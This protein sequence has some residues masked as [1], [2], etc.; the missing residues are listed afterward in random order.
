MFILQLPFRIA[1]SWVWLYWMNLRNLSGVSALLFPWS[2]R[3]L[4]S[5]MTLMVSTS[6]STIGTQTVR[7]RWTL[8]GWRNRG[9]WFWSVWL[10][11][12]L[13][14]KSTSISVEI[15]ECGVFLEEVVRF[16]QHFNT[17]IRRLHISIKHISGLHSIIS[18]STFF[19]GKKESASRIIW[20]S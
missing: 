1:A 13:F 4:P 15:T 6:W 12:W 2:S 5:P 3:R 9:S 17:M 11:M 16:L 18:A 19:K 14:A 8:F 10:S 7:W 20:H